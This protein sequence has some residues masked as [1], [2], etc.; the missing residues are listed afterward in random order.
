[1]SMS[2]CTHPAQWIRE[3]DDGTVYCS[4][5]RAIVDPNDY[6]MCTGFGFPQPELKDIDEEYSRANRDIRKR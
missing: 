4:V 6:S 2:E 5:C 1:M 3:R